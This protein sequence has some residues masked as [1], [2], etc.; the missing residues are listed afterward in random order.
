MSESD[1]KT[2]AQQSSSASLP[3]FGPSNLDL[4]GIGFDMTLLTSSGD[5]EASLRNVVDQTSK[6]HLQG[7]GVEFDEPLAEVAVSST[8]SRTST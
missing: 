7:M 4:L 1:T 2:A 8:N 6:F 3:T 5:G